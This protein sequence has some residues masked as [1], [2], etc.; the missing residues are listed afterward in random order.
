MNYLPTDTW[1]PSGGVLLASKEDIIG[2]EPTSPKN[3]DNGVSTFL[4]RINRM[5]YVGLLPSS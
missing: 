5:A 3:L 2:T 1:E 4:L